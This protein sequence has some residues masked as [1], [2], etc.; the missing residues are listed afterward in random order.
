LDQMWLY[1][2]SKSSTSTYS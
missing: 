1:D 2:W